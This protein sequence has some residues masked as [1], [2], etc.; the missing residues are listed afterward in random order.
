MKSTCLHSLEIVWRLIQTDKIRQRVGLCRAERVCNGHC[1]PFVISDGIDAHP[2]PRR[3]LKF[4][5]F[6]SAVASLQVV[7]QT[8]GIA[9]VLKCTNLHTPLAGR[10]YPGALLQNLNPNLRHTCAINTGGFGC[11]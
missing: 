11:G 4:K 8:E 5:N 7:L 2:V 9:R 6:C 1:L 3:P 10:R